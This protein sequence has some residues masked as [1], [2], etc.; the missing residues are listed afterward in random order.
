MDTVLRSRF[1]R[2]SVLL[3]PAAIAAAAMARQPVPDYGFDWQ[4]VGAAANL[5]FP[6]AQG[7]GN[8]KGRA[9]VPYPYGI[10]RTEVTT[11]QYLAFVEAYAPFNEAGPLDILMTGS[12][13]DAIPD[14]SG[15]RYEVRPGFEGMP[16]NM[17]FAGC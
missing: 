7:T 12:F 17:T 1:L 5:P 8:F 2:P 10:A 11:S 13:I 3:A 6:G 15:Y 16:T 14:G 4:V 9:S